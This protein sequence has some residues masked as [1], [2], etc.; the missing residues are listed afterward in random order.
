VI[1]RHG[2]ESRADDYLV[3]PFAVAEPP[4]H[5]HAI[6]RRAHSESDGQLQPADVTQ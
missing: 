6:A 5:A 2:L 4:A 3:K 1:G